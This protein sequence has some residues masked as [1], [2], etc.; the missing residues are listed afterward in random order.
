MQRD[1]GAWCSKLATHGHVDNTRCLL[2]GNEQQH[3]EL[4]TH[5]A[6]F[7]SIDEAALGKAASKSPSS[8]LTAAASAVGG[9][10]QSTVSSGSGVSPVLFNGDGL[11]DEVLGNILAQASV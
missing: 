11:P 10:Q 1:H 2:T 9:R 6:A 8:K 3:G 7:I 5:G 4:D